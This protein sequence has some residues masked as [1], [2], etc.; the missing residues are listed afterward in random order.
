MLKLEDVSQE[1]RGIASGRQL[2][3]GAS[4]NHCLQDTAVID[5]DFVTMAVKEHF[6]NNN[7]VSSEINGEFRSF[8]IFGGCYEICCTPARP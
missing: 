1:I 5:D 6:S 2:T 4:V 8:Q 3:D 7:L